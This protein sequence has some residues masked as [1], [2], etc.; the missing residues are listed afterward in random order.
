MSTD[1]RVWR[2]WII[3]PKALFL[4]CQIALLTGVLSCAVWSHVAH[5]ESDSF[6]AQP[7]W[8]GLILWLVS[9][10][11]CCYFI[12]LY[13]TIAAPDYSLFLERALSSLLLGL[14]IPLPFF[15]A[16]PTF[17]PGSWGALTAI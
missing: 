10:Q 1:V 15:A 16:F 9:T 14:L 5:A 4:F 11:L 8:I 3:R 2:Y 12:H 6:R 13:S 17:Y 7:A